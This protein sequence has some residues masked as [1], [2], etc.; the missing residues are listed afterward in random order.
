MSCSCFGIGSNGMLLRL[1]LHVALEL[2]CFD[3]LVVALHVRSVLHF[4]G[5][6]SLGCAVL[7]QPL[8]LEGLQDVVAHRA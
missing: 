6:R 4:C 2:R 5:Q 7:V 8:D 3:L 1:D